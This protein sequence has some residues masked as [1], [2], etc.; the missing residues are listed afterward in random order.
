MLHEKDGGCPPAQHTH[1]N[2][3]TGTETETNSS[4]TPGPEAAGCLV[5]K[6]LRAC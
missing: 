2:E 5:D 6:L 4:K 3:F 1:R